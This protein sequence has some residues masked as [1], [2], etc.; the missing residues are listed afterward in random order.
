MFGSFLSMSLEPLNQFIEFLLL[1]RAQNLSHLR[2]ARLNNVSY[3]RMGFSEVL[4]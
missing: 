2:K 1:I 3:L 4:L